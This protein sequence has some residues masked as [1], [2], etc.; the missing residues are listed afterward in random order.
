MKGGVKIRGARSRLPPHCVLVG[1]PGKTKR[2]QQ[3]DPLVHPILPG[4]ILRFGWQTEVT[5]PP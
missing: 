3:S 5:Y 1:A 4:F 2:G